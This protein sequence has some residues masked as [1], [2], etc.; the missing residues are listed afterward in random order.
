MPLDSHLPPDSPLHQPG[1]FQRITWEEPKDYWNI[2]CQAEH[3]IPSE[4][5][6]PSRDRHD[7]I[8]STA[9]TH[10]LMS[11]EEAAALITEAGTVWFITQATGMD[12]FEASRLC[13]AGTPW[14]L[15]HMRDE[16]LWAEGALS[17]DQRAYLDRLF[18]SVG[19]QQLVLYDLEV[20]YWA[21]DNQPK[22]GPVWQTRG[23][24][25]HVANETQED[26]ETIK[27]VAIALHVYYC[28]LQNFAKQWHSD[29]M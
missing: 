5:P 14:P 10:S 28:C 21:A 12:H 6:I 26:V 11:Q 3:E 15:R 29:M 24:W 25:E 4:S 13:L 20:A 7:G 19:K 16:G 17:K 22:D 8:E 1:T 23:Y 2:M 27:R 9:P 18:Q